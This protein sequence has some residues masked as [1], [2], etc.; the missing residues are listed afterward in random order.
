MKATPRALLYYR[1]PLDTEP[2]LEWLR[3]LRDAKGRAVIRTRLNRIEQGNFSNCEPIGEGVHELKI[4]FGPG[5]RVYFGE[6]GDRVILLCGGDKDTQVRDIAKARN[7]GGITTV[8]KR[9]TDYRS[10]LLEDL[11]DSD[12]AVN[13][14]NAALE[15]SPEMFLA[16]L[17]DVAEA[18]QMAKVAEMAGVSRESLYRMLKL[19]GNPT[20]RSFLGILKAVG[21]EFGGVRAPAKEPQLPIRANG[22]GRSGKGSRT[23]RA[24]KR[25]GD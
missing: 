7:T 12:E 14:L 24:Q 16:A 8:P 19:S 6:D 23:R 1:T 9:T 4:D 25:R 15:D 2:C 20:Y 13:Y 21:L 11:K 3:T 10:A 5:Y 22:G 17:R 18:R